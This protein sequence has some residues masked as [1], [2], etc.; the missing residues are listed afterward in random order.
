MRVRTLKEMTTT[1]LM[2]HLSI[3]NI[4]HGENLSVESRL[5]PEVMQ[6]ATI[7]LA[8]LM[9]RPRGSEGE[10]VRLAQQVRRLIKFGADFNHYGTIADAGR[11]GHAA[12]MAVLH[13]HGA[14]LEQSGGEVVRTAG[15]SDQANIIDFLHQ[16]EFDLSARIPNTHFSPIHWAVRYG[17]VNVYGHC[18]AQTWI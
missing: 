7:M 12:S 3:G 13:E 10:E 5:I 2:Q 4:P 15:S 11:N 1:A 6:N 17:A 8:E 18:L 16:Q 9:Q 14:D